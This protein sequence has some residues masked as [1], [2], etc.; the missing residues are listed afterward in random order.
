M[1]RYMARPEYQY[2]GLELTP[3]ERLK[4]LAGIIIGTFAI[5]AF[6]LALSVV[7]S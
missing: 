4:V 6:L 3:R 7:P 2:A 1:K 5:C